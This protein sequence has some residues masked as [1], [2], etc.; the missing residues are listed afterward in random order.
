M[1]TGNPSLCLYEDHAEE[2][3]L[4]MCLYHVL[5]IFLAG[6]YIGGKYCSFAV[7]L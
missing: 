4:Q 6:H 7:F 3:S 2:H 5:M 1:W